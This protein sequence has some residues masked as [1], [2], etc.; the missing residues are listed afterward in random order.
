MGKKLISIV[1]IIAM[2]FSF[3]GCNKGSERAEYKP[4]FVAE[5]TLLKEGV[6][7]PANNS[8]GVPMG[9]EYLEIINASANYKYVIYEETSEE[10]STVY[11]VSSAELADI[12]EN[13]KLDETIREVGGSKTFLKEN[14]ILARAEANAL[15]IIENLTNTEGLLLNTPVDSEVTYLTYNQLEWDNSAFGD[16]YKDGMTVTEYLQ[17]EDLKLLCDSP[18]VKK[19]IY[20]GTV[21]TIGWACAAVVEAEVFCVKNGGVYKNTKWIPKKGNSE[22][23]DFLVTFWTYT[24]SSGEHCISVDDIYVIGQDNKSIWDKIA[25]VFK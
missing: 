12:F 23:I 6:K 3:A 2:L 15:V 20:N 22:V 18:V 8:S 17:S 13:V 11:A 24:D 1:L 14:N 5:R 25:G 10:T 4:E 16:V 21:G 19:I 7:T 9:S